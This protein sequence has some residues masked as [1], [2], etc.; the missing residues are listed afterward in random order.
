MRRYFWSFDKYE[1]FYTNF[2]YTVSEC[3]EVA[4]IE[5]EEGDRFVYIAE[6]VTYKPSIDVGYIF[7]QLTEDACI[8]FQTVGESWFD[9][10]SEAKTEELRD[11]LNNVLLAWLQDLGIFQDFYSL[12]NHQVYDLETFEMVKDKE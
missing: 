10:I 8:E 9:N 4:K 1:D 5:A 12:N 3:L 6:G 11:G 7:D 2:A